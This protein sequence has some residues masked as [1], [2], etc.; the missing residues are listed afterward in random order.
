MAS[1][2]EFLKG[3]VGGKA[4]Y[5]AGPY[6]SLDAPALP[7]LPDWLPVRHY[8]GYHEKSAAVSAPP[9]AHR[10]P[11]IISDAGNWSIECSCGGI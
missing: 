4:V 7:S 9:A 3:S 5:A 2:R 10:H 1:R 6:T 11:M 8:G